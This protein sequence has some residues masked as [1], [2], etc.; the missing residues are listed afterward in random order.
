MTYEQPGTPELRALIQPC[1]DHQQYPNTR[2][3]TDADVDGCE[4]EQLTLFYLFAELLRKE[5]KV[6]EGEIPSEGS[7][8][9]E[10]RS[11]MCDVLRKLLVAAPVMLTIETIQMKAIEVG[12]IPDPFEESRMRYYRLPHWLFAHWKCGTPIRVV[13]V[14]HSERLRNGPGPGAGTGGVQHE[15]VPYCPTCEKA[16][17]PH[18][19]PVYI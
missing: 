16:P 14:H 6:K 1:I 3:M 13:T 17:N 12:A 8:W 19:A 5:A 15:E 18:G 11:E 7:P 9:A 2:K 4:S 10:V